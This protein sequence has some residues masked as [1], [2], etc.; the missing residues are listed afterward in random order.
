MMAT[1]I[2][3]E[4]QGISDDWSKADG[5]H[6]TKPRGE[7]G[8]EQ[9]LSAMLHLAPLDTPA[10]DDPCPPHVITRGP[11]G[12]FGFIGQGGSIFCPETDA[13]LTA[14]AACDTAFGKR[15]VAP[16][17]PMPSKTVVRN[18]ESVSRPPARQ[19][20]RFGWRS[21]IVMILSLG[22][23]WVAGAMAF[24]VSS[25]RAR[26]MPSDDINAAITI[27]VGL[28]LIGA[29]LFALA[30]KARR[31]EHFDVDG[32]HVNADGS[33]LPFVAMAESFGDY[34]DGD[35]GGDFDFD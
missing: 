26:G 19:R 3:V 4:T 28:A 6:A 17:P 15:A 24:G 29:L 16:P 12:D 22:A 18:T 10:G 30:F 5:D 9:V 20:R 31:T 11:A 7:L 23:F 8:H 27:G 21:W 33:A 1:I 14:Q 34:G 35:D 32:K 13:E 2:E 25:M